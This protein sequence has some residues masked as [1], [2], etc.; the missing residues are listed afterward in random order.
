MHTQLQQRV[1]SG[2]RPNGNELITL[3]PGWR[4]NHR[5][6][7]DMADDAEE[8]WGAELIRSWNSR[9][10]IGMPQ[11]LGA[12]IAPLIGARPN[13]VIVA[14]S[15][16]VNLYKLLVA[17]VDARPGRDVIVCCAD[18]FPTDRYIVAGVAEA[19]RKTV[20]EV[21]ADIDQGLDPALLAAALD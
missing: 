13:E 19:H 5:V 20:R 16:S 2:Q 6:P 1:A 8:Q 9:D 12:K 11:R 18:D 17:A 14:D 15:T 21:P 10:W 4:L 7:G 3:P